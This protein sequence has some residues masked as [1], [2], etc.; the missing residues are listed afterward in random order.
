[1]TPDAMETLMGGGLFV[2]L[3][4]AWAF[5]CVIL[6]IAPL[7]IWR[8]SKRTCSAVDELREAVVTL[9]KRLTA[10]QAQSLAE[11]RMIR[12][13]SKPHGPTSKRSVTPPTI[14]PS[15]AAVVCPECGA[16][17]EFDARVSNVDVVCPSCSK[18]FHIH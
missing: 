1:M 8:W 16:V 11:L 14:P 10:A 17:F 9:E 13:A 2:A 3:F 12:E 7:M 18:P 5:F 15:E 6:M 4:T